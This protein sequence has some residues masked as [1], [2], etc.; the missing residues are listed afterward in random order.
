MNIN[1]ELIIKIG[2]GILIVIVAVFLI[3]HIFK[4]II[5][6][7]RGTTNTK[8]VS[9]I[10]SVEKTG[11]KEQEKNYYKLNEFIAQQIIDSQD[12]TPEYLTKHEITSKK[13]GYYNYNTI[14]NNYDNRNFFQKN[15]ILY[16]NVKNLYNI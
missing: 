7:F 14:Q 16:H 3:Y 5:S 4:Y 1:I 12:T 6:L 13:D 11:I 10:G 15:G 9:K 8:Q 2:L